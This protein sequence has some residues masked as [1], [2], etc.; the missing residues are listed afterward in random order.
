MSLGSEILAWN[1]QLRSQFANFFNTG[2][3][4]VDYLM[5]THRGITNEKAAGER[6]TW[7]I[8]DSTGPN[9]LFLVSSF[10]VGALFNEAMQWFTIK[11]RVEEFNE[12]AEVSEYLQECKRV[13]FASLRQSN[14]YATPIELIQD[15]LAFGNL[16]VLQERI[17]PKAHYQGKL[18]FTPV[19]YGSYVF[20]EGRDKR[21]EGL[22][23]EVDMSAQECFRRWGENCSD[24]I[25][26]LYKSK[27]FSNV[28]IVHSITPRDLVAYRRLATPK[29]MPYASCWYEKNGKNKKPLEESGYMEKPFAIARYNVIAGEVMGRGLGELMLPHVKTL[30]GIMSRGFMDL[31]ISLDPP[32]DT[33]MNNIVGDYSHRPGSKNV[34][35]RLERTKTSQAAM[36]RRQRNATFEWNVNDLRQQI[37]EIAFVEHIR[38]LIGVEA[39]PVKEQTAFEYGKRLELVHMIMAPT[40]GRLQ[41]EGLKDIIDTN[42]AINYRMGAFPP[43]PDILQQ[44][45]KLN[46]DAGQ[47][48]VS[49]EGPLAKSQRQEEIGSMLEYLR[50]VQGLAQ[51]HPTALDIPNVDKFLR[52]D[53]E[54][55]GVQHLLNDES[56]TSEIR[57]L[58]GRIEQLQQQLAMAES[59]TQSMKNAAPMVTAAMG[60]NGNSQAA[61]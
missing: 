61:A 50:D 59:I 4:I 29:E 8:Y 5:P 56:E 44:A 43:T 9:S 12:N 10:L 39:S 2:Q 30:N 52:M 1:D 13:Q 16:C 22:I 58:K 54:I 21:P 51:T 31:D 48:D 47:I 24:E 41:T 33:E 26:R 3:E 57:A 14:F 45:M 46:P 35:R 60:Q 32:I 34:L 7:R 25:K 42:F 37:R 55:R 23:R 28:R 17:A 53:A 36:E 49:Y 6:Q 11:A 19:G 27:P 20:F 40:G 15:W 18:V 38:Q